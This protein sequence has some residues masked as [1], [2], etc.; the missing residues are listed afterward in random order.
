MGGAHTER[1]VVAKRPSSRVS[2]LSFWQ[3]CGD[4]KIKLKAQGKG[5]QDSKA[6]TPKAR[7]ARGGEPDTERHSHGGGLCSFHS[8]TGGGAKRPGR[9]QWPGC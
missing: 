1:E 9:R 5:G 7:G 6:K 2:E 8:S 3:S 4:V